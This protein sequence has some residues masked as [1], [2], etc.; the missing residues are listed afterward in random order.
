MEHPR[1]PVL[2]DPLST[3]ELNDRLDEARSTVAWQLSQLSETDLV[4]QQR[5]RRSVVDVL[6]PDR[7][8]FDVRTQMTAGTRRPSTPR[9]R[10]TPTQLSR[11]HSF[12]RRSRRHVDGSA[13]SSAKRRVTIG[14]DSRTVIAV[15]TGTEP[16][17][18]RIRP[19]SPRRRITN[20]QIVGSS[21]RN[22]AE[23]RFQSRRRGPPRSD[24]RNGSRSQ[25]P[26][27]P[28]I[29]GGEPVES[30][31]EPRQSLQGRDQGPFRRIPVDE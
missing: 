17:V 6:P 24:S 12:V 3:T 21:P 2:V 27:T 4:A 18:A 13:L 7:W 20:R 19:R 11:V 29:T 30:S 14:L 25:N 23:F 9:E 10:P 16:V 31:V 5:D 28:A 8:K 26:G 15:R 1:T 22:A